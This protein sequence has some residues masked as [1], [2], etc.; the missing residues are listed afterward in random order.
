M[1]SDIQEELREKPA[2]SFDEFPPPTYEAWKAAA[3]TTLKGAPFE[4]RLLTATHEGITLEPIYTADHVRGLPLEGALPGR[5]PFLR[6]ATASGYLARPWGVAQGC[7]EILPE[8]AGAVMKEELEKGATIIHF[9]L[10]EATRRGLDAAPA[11]AGG[12]GLSLSTLDDLDG[13]FRDLDPTGH[14]LHIGAGFSAAPLLGLF[15]ALARARGREAELKTCRGCVGAD[16][17][18]ALASSGSLPCPLDELYDEMAVTLR[19]AAEKMPAMK[20]I[21]IH[22][23]V[24]HDGGASATE[25]IACAAATAIAYIRAL[26]IRGFD[27]A[28][29]AAGMR[30]SLSLGA[31]FFMEIAKIR[32]MRRIGSAIIEAFGGDA[33]SHPID[34]FARTSRFTQ[35]VY[36]PYVNI[37][38]ATSQAFS[39]VVGG[40]AAMEVTRFDEAIRSGGE[41]SRRIA[42]NIQIMLQSEFDLT[43]PVDP[44]GGS[45]YIESLTDQVARKAWKEM[46]EIETSGGLFRSLSEGSVQKTVDAT[47]ER[48]RKKLATRSDR[49]VGTNMYANV[50]ERPLQE[51]RD[52]SALRAKRRAAVEA[53]RADIDERHC[54]ERLEAIPPAPGG[55]PTAFMESLAEAFFAG[56]TLQ[57]VRDRLNDGFEGTVAVAPL[58]PR[59]WTEPFEN[60]R[61]RTEKSA[62]AGRTIRVFLANMGPIPQH[63]ARADFSAGFMEVAHFEIL[64]NDGFDDVAKAAQAAVEA[65]ADVTVIC[66]TD[67]TYPDLVPPL[68]QAIR[69]ARPDMI[70]LLAGAP[71]PEHKETYL[72]AGVDNFIHV[73]AD[74]LKILT[75]IQKARGLC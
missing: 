48:R 53:F 71:A 40:V 6:G 10:D 24:Y 61:K 36:D 66:S 44:G 64:R 32:A 43:Q 31:N 56:A 9:V 14:P 75:D 52:L 13:L 47:L 35:T 55:D 3:E 7:D 23:D 12:R 2:V 63:K 29:I 15:A 60:L 68:A 18:G 17:L 38:R 34:I 50:L 62:E 33:D 20:T 16:P 45:W 4:K 46:Q 1:A 57:E 42:R 58:T 11:G 8:E 49:A 74:C 51:E 70:V 27:I 73:R 41:Q 25:E 54:L 19:W 28:E 30:F 5:A 59:R 67:E 39:G 22:G 21:L 72:A 37:L 69:K 65:E 26:Q